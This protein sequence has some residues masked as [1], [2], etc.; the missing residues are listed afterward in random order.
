[1][2]V[3]KP[4]TCPICGCVCDDLEVTVEDGQIK[5][6]KNACVLSISKFMNFNGEHRLMEPMIRKNGELQP[7]TL[8]EAVDEAVQI[9][10]GNREGE[11]DALVP[12][13]AVARGRAE[14]VEMAE[15]AAHVR[16]FCFF[17]RHAELVSASASHPDI[18][19]AAFVATDPPNRVT[20][21]G[22]LVDPETSSG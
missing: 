22:G 13:G 16:S 1:M 20:C 19:L 5:K 12:I 11:P 17:I 3:I 2:P 14:M 6:V 18:V 7:V 4:V 21:P 9:A 15:V 10:L 8:E